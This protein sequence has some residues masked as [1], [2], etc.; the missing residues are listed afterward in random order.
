[1]TA[2]R[3]IALAMLGLVIVIAVVYLWQMRLAYDRIAG[4]SQIIAAGGERIEYLQGGAGAPV[5]V[6]HGSG[7]GFDQGALIAGAVIG[8]GF[9][10]IAPSRFGYLG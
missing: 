9:R 8:D 2:L 10:W 6:V 7:G 4:Q 3:W 5:L 1:M